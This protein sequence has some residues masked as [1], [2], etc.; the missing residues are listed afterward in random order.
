M[1]GAGESL[2][3]TFEQT[4]QGRKGAIHADTLGKEHSRQRENS[5][6]VQKARV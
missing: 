4:A 3:M 6:E 5:K 1:V 2:K